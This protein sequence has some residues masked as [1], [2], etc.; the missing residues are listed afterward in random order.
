M[1]A[2]QHEHCTADDS[3]AE[4]PCPSESHRLVEVT[5]VLQAVLWY[6]ETSSASADAQVCEVKV[7]LQGVVWAVFAGQQLFQLTAVQN[8]L[9][10][11]GH[12]SASSI[13][14]AVLLQPHLCASAQEVSAAYNAQRQL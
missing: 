12:M 3:L 2:G 8:V 1:A 4:Q 5:R 13:V 11:T 7:H 9:T 10:G 6:R 14:T